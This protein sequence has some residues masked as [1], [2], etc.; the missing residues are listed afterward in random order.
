MKQKLFSL[1]LPFWFDFALGLIA[2]LTV[3]QTKLV[4]IGF[5]FLAGITFYGALKR[6]FTFQYNS[7]LIGFFLLYLAYLI[8]AIFTHNPG[9]AGRYLEYK[10]SFALIPLIFSFQPKEKIRIQF[11]I[12]GLVVGILLVSFLGIYRAFTLYHATGNVLLSFT[13]GSICLDH[14]TYYAAFLFISAVGVWTLFRKNTPGF[15]LKLVLPYLFF[16]GIMTFLSYAMAAIL[17]LL[18][19][20]SFLVVRFIYLKINK[21][22]AIGILVVAPIVLFY[23]VT[24]IPAFKDEI[25]NTRNAFS[26]YL[27]APSK[28][29]EGT[30]ETPSGDKVRLIMWTVSTNEILKHPMGVGTGN[31][32]EF[33]SYGLTAVHQFELA[34]KNEKKEIKY[35][36]HNQFLQTTLEIGIIGFLLLAWIVAYGFRFG[37][38]HKN[39]LILL[40]VASLVFNSLFESMLQ[41]QSGIVFYTF[42]IC[43][44]A[45]YLQ[46]KQSTIKGVKK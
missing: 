45:S 46:Q 37:L 24:H 32:D 27:A 29:I 20:I 2:F 21:F 30:K 19:V 22:L 9:A 36:P 15:T 12:I 10:L 4:A 41:R 11:P 13:S 38:Q 34:H 16:V 5:V 25:E 33:L 14:P 6:K 23:T 35:N 17:F 40:L 39:A 1:T 26:S 28:F 8:G 18:I 3:A 31:V 44:I 43:L 7:V 42:W